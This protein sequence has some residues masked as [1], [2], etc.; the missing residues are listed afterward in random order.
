M[1]PPAESPFKKDEPVSGSRFWI[2]LTAVSAVVWL[3]FSLWFWG[4]RIADE[5]DFLMLAI[6]VLLEVWLVVIL[7]RSGRAASLCRQQRN[8]EIMAAAVRAQ[9]MVWMILAIF[10]AAGSV[11][12]IVFALHLRPLNDHLRTSIREKPAPPPAGGENHLPPSS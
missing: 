9:R 10:A 2:L 3:G 1:E 12:F 8:F 4:P 6:A 5:V 7:C 11:S